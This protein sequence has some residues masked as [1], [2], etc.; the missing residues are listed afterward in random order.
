M[1]K[2]CTRCQFRN[3]GYRGVCQICGHA[4]FLGVSAA[5]VAIAKQPAP[6]L[7][8]LLTQTCAAAAA[9]IE[10]IAKAHTQAHA[11]E[12][13]TYPAIAPIMLAET[14]FETNDLDS[15][16][17]WFKAYGIDKPLIL[18]PKPK[19]DRSKAA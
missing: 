2:I 14:T 17:A 18:Q 7:S 1:E 6:S 8:M 9:A 5:A 11:Q 13:T 12:Q 4:K 3:P 15:M 19:S 16:L 10:N